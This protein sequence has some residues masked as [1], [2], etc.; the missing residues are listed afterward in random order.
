MTD[1]EEFGL[2][3]PVLEAVAKM[4][5]V[6]ATPIQ[7]KTIPLVLEGRDLLGQAQTGTGKTAAFGVSAAER[8]PIDEFVRGLVL[9]PTREL[10]MQVA[11]ELHE[12][13][14][15]TGHKVLPVYGGQRIDRQITA[16]KKGVQIVV[17]TPGRILD[18]L[19]RGT[20]K[21]SGLQML[22]LDEADMML[23]MG[24]LP[25]IRRII[26]QTP[27]E[28][29]TLLFS[30][31]IPDQIQRISR[32]YMRDAEF[33]SVVPETM[34]LE[35]TEQIFYEVP[36]DDK[37]EA[38]TRLLDY[39]EE[40]GTTM[41]FCRTRRNVDKL[42]RKLK[43]RGY[44]VEGL[45]GD[46]TQQQRE[47]IIADFRESR[48]SYLVATDVASRGL[49]ISHVTHVINYHVP[50]DPEAYVHRIG[51]TGRMGRSGMAIT[52]V[53]PAEYWDLLRIQEFSRAQIEPGELPTE[54]EVE[55]RR[56]ASRGDERARQRVR[57]A[58]RGPTREVVPSLVAVGG[59]GLSEDV[60]EEVPA[61]A[62]ASV[63]APLS[64]EPEESPEAEREPGPV[65]P[66]DVAAALLED[67]LETPAE[68]EGKPEARPR[69]RRRAA[70]AEPER[71]RLFGLPT[72]SDEPATEAE[73]DQRRFVARDARRRIEWTEEEE[74]MR[75]AARIEHEE[76]VE[77]VRAQATEETAPATDEEERRREEAE[78]E[79]RRAASEE[80]YRTDLEAR[81]AE[82]AASIPAGAAPA[83]EAP[84][85]AEPRPAADEETRIRRAVELR[86]RV[87]ALVRDLD[88]SDLGDFEAIV[89]RLSQ[90][91]DLRMITA[92]LLKQL[93]GQAREGARRAP[94]RPVAGGPPAAA[95]G[96]TEGPEEDEG[97]HDEEMT[98][99]FIS[100]GRRARMTKEKLQQLVLE[101]AGI[102]ASE[103]GRIDL[104]HNFA[105]V[106]VRRAVA[107]R[108]VEAMH[109][110]IFRGR[111]IS[112]A[113][114]K[115]EGREEE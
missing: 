53:T 1:F 70:E 34:T 107:S 4:G 48:F 47:R 80:S 8:L 29:Q 14:L 104:L 111:E 87:A 26:R 28:R 44:D 67:E 40:G 83:G 32:E 36:E 105:F 97:E 42:T 11:E 39:A 73:R 115:S 112:V 89:D 43:S 74:S 59:D 27:P 88:Q 106:E 57:Q 31:T 82:A 75:E 113:P 54:E 69:R 37:I 100:V 94:A 92:A 96:E 114:A 41:I 6:E 51:R 60:A 17:G 46:L 90:D 79:A 65:E 95:P 3:A 86:D 22:V 91:A 93:A 102:D 64:D 72:P 81:L 30:A 5:F 98:R 77:R 76:L 61:L 50:Q 52:F 19:G 58:D 85:E 2:S 12:I 68:E 99:L 16:L 35:D 38:L 21:L 78:E 56:R 24:F 63:A 108:V 33:I 23:D 13:T 103:I 7:K 62:L 25:D 101:T 84:A 55:E 18:H 45:H 10:A 15:F 49:D 71:E 66:A 110:S 20:L 9:C 109:E